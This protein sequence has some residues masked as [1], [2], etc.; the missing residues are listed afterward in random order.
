MLSTLSPLFVAV[1][2][3]FGG[4]NEGVAVSIRSAVSSGPKV[5]LVR[6]W[7]NENPVSGKPGSKGNKWCD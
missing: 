2:F 6:C 1:W 5:G 7:L 4:G 3:G